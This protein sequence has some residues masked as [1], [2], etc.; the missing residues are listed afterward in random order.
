MSALLPRIC[1]SQFSVIQDGAAVWQ[2]NSLG[3]SL[4]LKGVVAQTP[5]E[6]FKLDVR[7]LFVDKL[8]KYPAQSLW[9]TNSP[10]HFG[11]FTGTF[12]AIEEVCSAAPLAGPLRLHFPIDLGGLALLSCMGDVAGTPACMQR[13]SAG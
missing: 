1:L 9:R 10:T 4:V 8:S 7:D 5:W 2:A 13:G 12:T 6:A 3:D 11:G